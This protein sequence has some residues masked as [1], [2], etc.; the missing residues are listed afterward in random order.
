MKGMI[1]DIKRYAIHDGPGIRTTVFFKGCSLRCPW[2]HNPEGIAPTPEF[3]WRPNRCP[4]NCALCVDA[5]PHTAIQK[6]GKK[7]SIDQTRCELSRTCE[8]A[9]VYEALNIVGRLVSVEEVLAEVERDR[10]F[11]DE[12]G[13][14]VTLSGGEPLAQ[15][16]FLRILLMEIR[17]KGIHIALD[18]AG[19]VPTE[20]LE[21]ICDGVDLFLFDLKMMDEERHRQFCGTS[22][23]IILENLKRLSRRGC[24]IFIRIPLIS[25]INDDDHNIGSIGKFLHTLRGIESINFL[26]Y[27]RGGTE[28]QR[29]L[30][31]CPSMEAFQP[32]SP[33][34][35]DH[36]EELLSDL[37]FAVYIGG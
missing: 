29:R 2:C 14:G 31:E 15:Y 16:E 20:D 5:C 21:G 28:K 35:L 27:H 37:G 4:E 12:S 19:Y 33:E 32:P 26:P 18:T 23:R 6:S 24:R 36:L 1:F 13:G 10:I 30:R 3:M 25:G 34:R 22:N 9:C 7:I 17:K 11:Y 8:E